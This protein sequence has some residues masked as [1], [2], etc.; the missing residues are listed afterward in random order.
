VKNKKVSI[1]KIH[2]RQRADTVNGWNAH[3]GPFS[4]AGDRQKC[5][6]PRTNEFLQIYATLKMNSKE[7]QKM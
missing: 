1:P 5:S 4:G 7:G 6:L 3:A 2:E